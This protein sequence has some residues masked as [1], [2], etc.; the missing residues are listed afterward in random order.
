MRGPFLFTLSILFLFVN[1]ILSQET[2]GNLEGRI[3]DSE[4][5]PIASANIILNSERMQGE[6]GTTSNARGYFYAL[7]LS[8]GIYT[9]AISHVGKQTTTVE[10][11]NV[12]LGKTTTLGEVILNEAAEEISEVII[13]SD[14]P[15]ID[16]GSTTIGLNLEQKAFENL[17]IQRDYKSVI[18]LSPLATQ[19]F[20]GDGVNVSGST[21]WENAYFIDG[22][23]V[24]DPTRIAT[25][26][27]LPYNFIKE[28]EVKNGGYQAEYGKALGTIA[29]V[30]THQG[31]NQFQGQVFGFFTDQ[32]FAGEYKLG[33][34]RKRIKDF[35]TYDFGISLGGPIIYDKLWYFIAYNPTF[36]D[37]DVEIPDV[38]IYKDRTRS[39]LFAGKLTWQPTSKTNLVLTLLGDPTTQER[40]EQQLGS[41]MPVSDSAANADPYL[42][43]IKTGGYSLSLKARHI[44]NTEFYLEA[45]LSAATNFFYDVASTDRGRLESFFMDFQDSNFPVEGGYGRLRENDSRRLLVSVSANYIVGAHIF[46][47]GLAYEDNYVDDRT[48]NKA[49]LNAEY[50]TPVINNPAG[51]P[52][53]IGWW[54]EKD[55][56]VHNRVP[57]FFLQDS[58]L[59]TRRLRINAGIRW[60]GQFMVGSDGMVAQKI[61]DQ[62][63]P[64][65]GFTYQPGE[66][67]SQKIFGSFGRFYEQLPLILTS[68]Y[69]A[70]DI[71]IKLIYL[72]DPRENPKG[73]IDSTITSG[74]QPEIDGLKG[75][76]FDEVVLGYERRIGAE[77]KLGIQGI[78]RN[79]GEVVEDGIEVVVDENGKKI[80]SKFMGNPG[81]GALNFLPEFTR[82]YAALEITFQKPRGNLNFLVSYVL[83]RNF[84]NYPGVFD[85]DIIYPEANLGNLDL[86]EQLVN[87]TG[88][89]PN[90][91][92]HVFKFFGSYNFDFGLSAGT[93]FILQSGTPLNAYG[94]VPGDPSNVVFHAERG[95]AGRTP[96]IWDWNIRLSYDFGPTLRIFSGIKLIVDL[97]HVLSRRE[98]V[99]LQQHKYLSED[100]EGN[101]VPSPNYLAVEVYQAP[102]TIRLGFEINF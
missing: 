90:D 100:G 91:R 81:K 37:Q 26:T 56:R 72:H 7:K 71:A 68:T 86:P 76:Y 40:V 33:T 11:V 62:W 15:V 52:V 78:Y 75:Q 95:S 5:N 43:D 82:E 73:A 21:G 85:S 84:G 59:A 98:A 97:F 31:G 74:I 66:I 54:A 27:N 2:T 35:A 39:H 99:I 42:G 3:L 89:L 19:S 8:V 69:S 9:V 49:G 55:V 18:S 25:G 48:E 101:L 1:L 23:N 24:T 60:D 20:Y 6:R 102:M 16:P 14:K 45:T 38:G 30:I 63:Q 28:V 93:S 13:S 70:N 92:T 94:A 44:V 61:L 22:V 53:Y 80:K 58:W 32:S 12:L 41:A 88:L 67:G 65:L 36:A 64:R 17:P 50:P 29:N 96:T 77:F 34:V 10:K 47:A 87:A 83:S 57:S 46:K 51:G 79:L 4:R